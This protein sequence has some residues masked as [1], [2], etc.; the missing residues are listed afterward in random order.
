MIACSGSHWLWFKRHIS[1][2]GN[3]RRPSERRICAF[4]WQWQF[5]VF[6]SFLHIKVCPVNHDWASRFIGIYSNRCWRIKCL[7]IRGDATH[8]FIDIDYDITTF[9]FRESSTC[10]IRLWNSRSSTPPVKI[11]CEKLLDIL[12][13]LEKFSEISDK[14]SEKFSDDSEICRDPPTAI[15]C[16]A[17]IFDVLRGVSDILRIYFRL[18]LSMKF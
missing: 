10:R 5:S 3:S 8:C 12:S 17:G 6:L 1:M 2:N 4:W 18:W 13:E 15:R 16:R 14:S 9:R 7:R 11:V